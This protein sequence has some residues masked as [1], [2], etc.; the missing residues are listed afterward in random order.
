MASGKIMMAAEAATEWA[1]S[2]LRGR[3]TNRAEDIAHGA[4]QVLKNSSLV[5]A[6]AT[7]KA[8]ASQQQLLFQQAS[9]IAQADHERWLDGARGP[10]GD[11]THCT[12]DILKAHIGNCMEHTILVC[13][14]VRDKYPGVTAHF[15]GVRDPSNHA[16]AIIGADAGLPTGTGAFALTTD[17]P[18]VALGAFAVVADAWW[19]EIFPA[20]S[21]VWSQKLGHI[22]RQTLVVPGTPLPTT[23]N[24]DCVRY[25]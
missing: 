17:D 10:N 16:F 2:A 12:A 22:L 3:A 1:N 8:E 5:L 23:I 24:A 9:D 13:E 19:H 6:N 25:A 21:G 4:Q 20:R 14:Y 7:T 15:I 18:P 11:G